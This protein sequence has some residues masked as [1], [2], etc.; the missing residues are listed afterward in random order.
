M[1]EI[2]IILLNLITVFFSY[3]QIEESEKKYE[4]GFLDAHVIRIKVDSLIN[5]AKDYCI[6][7]KGTLCN[8]YRIDVMAVYFY[9]PDNT[10]DSINLKNIKYILVPSRIE[11]S[12]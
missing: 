4:L 3:S 9:S 12:L 11:D 6:Y 1:K 10:L 5:K 7:R 8:L 2:T